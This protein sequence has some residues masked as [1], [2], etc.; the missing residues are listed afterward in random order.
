[1]KVE[2]QLGKVHNTDPAEFA[3]KTFTKQEVGLKTKSS[4]RVLPI[5][6]L[7]FE[8]ILEERQKYER[9][10]SRR[11]NDKTEPFF[12]GDYICCSTYGRPRSKGFHW[13]YYKQ[14]LAENGLPD[15]RWH[16]LRSTYCTLLLKESFS[17][18][19]ISNLMGHSKEIISINI[20]GD[21]RNIIA[22]GVP[23]IE[24]YLK[25]VLPNPEAIKAFNKELLEIVINTEEYLASTA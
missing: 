8:A 15:I 1:M 17:A 7:V 6:D 9:N 13:K 10:R 24:E 16:D 23:E 11:I 21:N 3:P 20:Y 4:Y 25:D 19:A 12:D 22:D 5:P 18:K 2:R 14:L